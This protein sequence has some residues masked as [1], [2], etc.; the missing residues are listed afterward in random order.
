MLTLYYLPGA[1][2]T[3][4]HVALE[5]S[6]LAYTA[7]AIS[8]EDTK[9]ERYLAMNPQGQVPLLVDGDWTLTQ[10]MAIID[11]INDLSPESHIFGAAGDGDVRARARARQW[12][13]FANS[14]LHPAFSI[15][16]G[17]S[18]LIEGEQAQ[19]DL[20]AHA[21]QKVL[22]LYEKVDQA[23]Q[24]HAFLAGDSI[25]IADVYVFVT[26]GW[27]ES[28]GLDV[29]SFTH[30]AGWRERVLANTGVQYALKEQGLL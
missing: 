15:M 17:A 29:S 18:R 19:A 3:V 9:S 23:L 12:L 14:D 6:G 25:S 16:F 10:N 13:A 24:Q 26:L 20:Q 4:P 22:S 21:A 5:W 11:Y 7:E 28:L 1:C 8:R 30:I 27:A 2:S